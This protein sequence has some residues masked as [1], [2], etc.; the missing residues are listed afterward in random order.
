M[1]RSRQLLLP[2]QHV[3]NRGLFSN[4]WFENRLSLEPEWRELRGDAR[5]ALAKLA[6]LWEREKD[7]VEQYGTE[8]PLE[9]AF[10]Q[11]VFD[12][13]GW[14]LK[15]QTF[16]RG[17]RPDYALFLDDAS[18]D[19]AL[20]ADRKSP[21]FWK[22][23]ALVADAKAWHI[24]LNRPSKI[25]D[26]REYP[27]QQI[28]WY[29]DRSRLDFGILT[30]GGLWRLV[31]REYTPQ[32]RRFQAYLECDLAKLLEEWQNASTIT[33]R[34]SVTEE[35]LQFYLFFSPAGY[36]GTDRLKPLV[37]RAIEGSSEYRVGVGEGLRQRAFEALRFCIEG[38]LNYPP[39]ELF[40]AVDLEQCRQESFILLYRLL[41]IMYAEDR[42]L[43]PYRLNRTYT[44]NRSLGR[45]RDEIAGRMDRIR[46]G[47]E[48]D[49]S[50]DSTDIWEDVQSLFDLVDGGHKRYGVPEYNGGLFD[51]KAHPFLMNKRISD[52]Y[53]ARIID[54]LGRA[55]D[56]T[57]PDA[58]ISR[59]DYRDLA[60]QHLGGIYEGLL[61]LQPTHA[62]E[63]T[64]VIS[65]RIKGQ[66]VEEYWPR[67]KPIPRGYQLT[68][69]LYRKGSIYLKTKK[70][71]RRASGSYY[72]PDHIVDYIV[73]NTLGTMCKTM[74]E[75]LHREIVREERQLQK[76][77]GDARAGHEARLEQL[78]T[79][80]DD[81]VLR[82]RVLDP[83]M[84]SGHFLIRAC[85]RLAEEIATHPYTGDENMP[86]DESA[87]SYWK[88][89]VV[90]T[91]L[92]GVDLNGLAVELAKL[93]LWLET[94]AADEPLSFLNH[95]LHQGN[96]LVGSRIAGLGVL[97]GEIELRSNIFKEQVEAK[98]PALLQPLAAIAEI[99][100]DTA[101]HVKEKERLYGAFERAR[102]PFRLVGDLWCSAF[103][104]NT[105]ITSEQFQQA[106]EELGKP[107]RFARLAEQE[108]FQSA[109][110]T[111]NKEFGRCFHWELEFP[112]AFFDGTK[113]R[114]NAGFDAVI[115][116]PPYDVLSEREIGRD[117][118]AFKAF[119]EAEPAYDPSRKG[120]NNLYKVFVCGALT[121]L[122]EGGFLGFITPMAVLGDDQAADLRRRIVDVGSFIAIEAFPQKDNPSRRVFPEAKLSTAV[123][124]IAKTTANL[125]E[126]RPF[127]SR[128]HPS[129]WIDA[130]SPSVT[131]GSDSI[132]LYDPANLTIVSCSQKDWDFAT[133]IMR[134]GRMKRLGAFAESF[135]GEVNE[136]NDRKRGSISYEEEDGP[137]VIRG[138]HVCL[139][140][141]RE[142]SQGTPVYVVV[143]RFLD[144]PN[145]SE[146]QKVF[147][148]RFDRVGFQRKSPQNNF[149]R[150]IATRIRTGTFLL[151]SVSYIPAH[152]CRIP[153]EIVLAV[154]NSK[155]ADW[156]FR[157]GSTNAMVGEYQ[158]KN[159][160]CPEFAESSSSDGQ[161][162]QELS[163][164]IAVGDLGTVFDQVFPMLAAAPFPAVVCG[165]I[166]TAV[167]RICAIERERGGISRAA[168]SALDPAA[169]P[170]QDLIDQLLYAMAGLTADESAALEDRLTNM[171]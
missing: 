48:Q 107:R 170:Y 99:P 25:D 159:L 158:V 38:F 74:S 44:D 156:Y 42:R 56:P 132:A 102:E 105:E 43:L 82:L 116:N 161:T 141:T 118:T 143:D 51:N 131:S 66:L 24:P 18:L 81:R 2:I 37:Y 20:A 126:A 47:E 147:H 50:Y 91:C 76:A 165:V 87:V 65:R 92:Y 104:P 15:Y 35:F 110:E 75:E 88:R 136:T 115:G 22:H 130:D 89:R 8:A 100:S 137:E 166:V 72:T 148:H 94:V 7:R 83:A 19:A 113:R 84:G 168:R 5:N 97:P 142:A 62:L 79:D 31:P 98:I 30:N 169:Q 52:H 80:F 70:G 152:K 109:L 121:L 32:Q 119:I 4:H 3:R 128:V 57:H 73:E 14:K 78:R 55:E 134:S 163:R 114:D 41:F 138:A 150:L 64:L 149:R 12:A 86:E 39:N 124:I 17:R 11:P 23:P 40:P 129:R 122:K 85:Q 139:Y 151:E 145:A 9:H 61:E 117:L 135:Q 36:R 46:N 45:H 133:K 155:L 90:E 112:E 67:S 125:Q 63:D 140:A 123:F 167:K 21:E 49:F 153:L 93:A 16:L 171:L 27:P 54:Q 68:E 29:L 162:L 106:V 96:S 58:G 59:V 127:V 154:M 146:D 10:I 28:E 101:D 160:P 103:C 53:M 69:Q 157:L 26:Q 95:H 108:W 6:S 164:R 60:I 144:R 34:D 13:L 33:E 1:P 71:E 111:A 77:T 120:K